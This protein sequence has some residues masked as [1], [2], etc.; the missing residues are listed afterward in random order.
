MVKGSLLPSKEAAVWYEATW[1]VFIACIHLELLGQ[2]RES[3]WLTE[4]AEEFRKDWFTELAEE[5][6]MSMYRIVALLQ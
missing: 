1:Y 2:L 3:V 6:R 4:L 5:F